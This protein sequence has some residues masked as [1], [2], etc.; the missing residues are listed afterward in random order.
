MRLVCASVC[1]CVS[2]APTTQL[3]QHWLSNDRSAGNS[4]TEQTLRRAENR[5]DHTPTLSDSDSPLTRLTRSA[6]SSAVVRSVVHLSALSPDVPLSDRRPT[7]VVCCADPLSAI[8]RS[9]H[10]THSS[11]AH[12]RCPTI[13]RFDSRDSSRY[14]SDTRVASAYP[15]RVE[16]CAVDGR[17]DHSDSDSTDDSQTQLSDRRR[18][19]AGGILADATQVD[20]RRRSGRLGLTWIPLR[21]SLHREQTTHSQEAEPRRIPAH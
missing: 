14:Q 6:H 2:S 1:V 8:C 5:S 4:V 19:D 11:D 9:R 16:T 18:S 17:A 21:P 7:G 15:R 13:G 12:H 20:H 3:I 10:R